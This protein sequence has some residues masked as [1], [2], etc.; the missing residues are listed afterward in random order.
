MSGKASEA[1]RRRGKRYVKRWDPV[2]GKR[3]KL[4]RMI[5]AEEIGRS[6]LPGEV[7]HHLDGDSLNGSGN[8][9]QL[10]S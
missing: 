4:H 2:L 6:L 8:L 9:I 5:A 3:V 1:A 7:V 10:L